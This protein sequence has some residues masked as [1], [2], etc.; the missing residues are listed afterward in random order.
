MIQLYI[1]HGQKTGH[2]EMRNNILA[3]H[4]GRRGYV[5]INIV[6]GAVHDESSRKL[7]HEFTQCSPLHG[8]EIKLLTIHAG[9]IEDM[10]GN[11]D[12]IRQVHEDE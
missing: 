6:V 2:R 12:R 5:A 8:T 1:L 11:V 9:K 4:E 3:D 10:S 7:V